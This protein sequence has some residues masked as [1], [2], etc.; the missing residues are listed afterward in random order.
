MIDCAAWIGPY[1]FREVPHPD[2]ATLVRGLERER[3]TGA[4]VG[5]L[6]SAWQRDPRPGNA[7][8]FAA[9][10]PYPTL[11]PAPMIRPDWP[12]WEQMLADVVQKGAAAIRAYPQHWGIEPGDSRMNAPAP[13]WP[14]YAR[15]LVLTCRFED[16][17]QRSPLDVAGHLSAAHVRALARCGEDVCVV[18]TGAVRE[19]IEE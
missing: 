8:L 11:L 1:P 6:P 16:L 12:G 4:W 18:V 17:R 15:P 3:L 10:A 2:A 14:A 19:L 7:A 9:L 5:Y 13:A